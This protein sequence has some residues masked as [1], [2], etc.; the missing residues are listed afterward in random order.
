MVDMQVL[1]SFFVLPI[2]LQS[3]E[4]LLFVTWILL[5]FL[6]NFQ[7]ISQNAHLNR[8]VYFERKEYK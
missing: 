6:H 5:H 7:I 2:C 1:A 3:V 8:N 4:L